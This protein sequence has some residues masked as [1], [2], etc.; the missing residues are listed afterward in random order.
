MPK[1]IFSLS[2]KKPSK[3]AAEQESSV[4][5]TMKNEEIETEIETG[6]LV[7]FII[8]CFGCC[9]YSKSSGREMLLYYRR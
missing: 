8:Y 3:K 2:E 5:F 4:S 1:L 7:N 9:A 6:I